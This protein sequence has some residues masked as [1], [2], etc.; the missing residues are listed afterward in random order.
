MTDENLNEDEGGTTANVTGEI[1]KPDLPLEGKKVKRR[2]EE[3]VQG[4]FDSA[5]SFIVGDQFPAYEA[6]R[7]DGQ[8]GHWVGGGTDEH[9]PGYNPMDPR[10]PSDQRKSFSGGKFTGRR[11][12]VRYYYSVPFAK[13]DEA[14]KLGLRFDPDKKAWYGYGDG[15]DVGPFKRDYKAHTK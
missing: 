6:A 5:A 1:A 10:R 9:H 12:H 14:K 3:D 13:K 7:W 2:L 8:V 4:I 11:D 15:D